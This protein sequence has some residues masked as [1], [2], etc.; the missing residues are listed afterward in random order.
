MVEADKGGAILLVEPKLLEAKV[1]EKV[2][3]EAM[4]NKLPGDPRKDQYNELI[5]IWRIGQVNE[6]V[7]TDECSKIVGLTKNGYKSTSSIFK[8][9][10]TYFVPSLKI[11]KVTPEN[12]TPEKAHEIP[13]RLITC[14]QNSTTKRSDV[15]TAEKWLK[16]LQK[17]YCKDLVES[18]DETLVWLDDLNKNGALNNRRN[19]KSFTFDFE[20]LYDSLSPDLV[21]RALRQAISEC[22]P[23]WSDNFIDWLCHLLQFSM[24]SA[25]GV[26]K[27]NWYK[28]NKGIPT[29]GSVSVPLANIAVYFVLKNAIYADQNKMR[30]I[31]SIRR[32]IDD[33]AGIHFMSP[34]EFSLWRKVLTDEVRKYGLNIKESEWNIAEISSDSV[35]FLDILF[36]IEENGKIQTDLYIKPTDSRSYLSFESC[37]PNHM[38][39]GIVYTQAL[40][41]R[42]IVSSNERLIQQLDSL[43]KAFKKC[44]YPVKLVDDI[45]GKVKNLPRVLKRKDDAPTPGKLSNNDVIMISTF[46]ADGPLRDIVSKLPNKEKLCIKMVSKTAP[47]LKSKF[48]TPKKTCLGPSKGVSG[49]CNRGLRCQCCDTMSQTNSVMDSSNKAFRTGSGNCTSKNVIYHL[50]C[51]VCD[52]PYVGKTVQMV[53]NRL[54]GH[55]NKFFEFI[56]LNGKIDDIDS[57]KEEYIPGMHLYNCHNLR[58]YEDFNRNLTVSILEKCNPSDLDVKEHL[59]IQKL[60]T[61]NPLGLNSVDPFGLPLLM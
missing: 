4:Y 21:M 12:L 2:E 40:R 53:S 16:D 10:D 34:R 46:G 51:K 50:K 32:F 29:G 17:D 54:S 52:Q 35:N 60:R 36:W 30:S 39:A 23:N 31:V 14:L 9:G 45:I 3:N 38:F 28:P 43:S 44:T 41:I 49:K 26:F 47:S 11:H 5:R 25:V 13:S 48:C 1:K 20:A 15:F 24:E 6:F 7:S 8:P 42:R 59:W 58:N 55:R 22:R 61:L 19:L 33:G 37:H 57:D 18:T 56:R 27:D